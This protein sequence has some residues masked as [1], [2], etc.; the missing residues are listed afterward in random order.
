MWTKL[1]KRAVFD[2]PKPT[3]YQGVVSKVGAKAFEAARKRLAVL[4]QRTGRVSDGDV[5]EYLARGEA[6]TVKYLASKK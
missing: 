5:F 3:R 1:G 2:L 4:A 6:E